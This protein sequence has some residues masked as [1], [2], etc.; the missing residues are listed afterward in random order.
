MAGSI[1]FFVRTPATGGMEPVD[2]CLNER[3]GF[4]G[5]HNWLALRL[6]GPRIR[7]GPLGLHSVAADGSAAM[8]A[9][10]RRCSGH[11]AVEPANVFIVLCFPCGPGRIL[12]YRN[13]ELVAARSHR[14]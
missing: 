11:G 1:Y 9:L 4:S 7:S 14:F 13:A 3:N 12:L 2:A 8:V 10:G 6:R 5:T